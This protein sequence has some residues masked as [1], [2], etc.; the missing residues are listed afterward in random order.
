[1]LSS[2]LVFSDSKLLITYHGIGFRNTDVTFPPSGVHLSDNDI[3]MS[4]PVLFESRRFRRLWISEISEIHKGLGGGG[5]V[6][7]CVSRSKKWNRQLYDRPGPDFMVDI[8]IMTD[9]TICDWFTIVWIDN[10]KTNGVACPL[11][12]IFKVSGN[13]QHTVDGILTLWW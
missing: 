8:Q 9:I 5:R 1:M 13:I 10:I 11:S 2:L 4:L 3:Q 12:Y 7:I 6:D